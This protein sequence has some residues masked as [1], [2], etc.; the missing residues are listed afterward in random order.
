MIPQLREE[1]ANRALR[2]HQHRLGGDG[3]PGRERAVAARVG[4]DE[5]QRQRARGV[6]PCSSGVDG[7]E[8]VGLEG[9][10]VLVGVVV[11]DEEVHGGCSLFLSFR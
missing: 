6:L 11:G 1:R 10:V 8:E 4:D 3:P 7:L 2:R 5:V 9:G